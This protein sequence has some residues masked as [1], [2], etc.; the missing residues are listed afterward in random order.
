MK[1]NK[2]IGI[3]VVQ[4]FKILWKKKLAIIL[5]AVVTAL[6]AFGCE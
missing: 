2:E 3:D 4:L 1:E 5:T 6:L